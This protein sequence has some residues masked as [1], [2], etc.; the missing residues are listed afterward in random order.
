M[1]LLHIAII[2]SFLI[3]YGH[4]GYF[5]LK[6]RKIK[7]IL[8]LE[9]ISI[10]SVHTL[11]YSFII[12]LI[13]TFAIGGVPLNFHLSIINILLLVLLILALVFVI[14]SR[15]QLS[16]FYSPHIEILKNHQLI[17]T[18]F[19]RY[20][21]HPIYYSETLC[22]ICLSFLVNNV[23]A[24]L[25]MTIWTTSILI[26]IS[27]EDKLLYKTFPKYQSDWSKLA[28]FFFNKKLEP[29]T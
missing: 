18:G 24:Y 17:D 5:F 9:R 8:L 21:S 19:Y 3:V 29:K 1:P 25:G 20:I 23:Y 15:I 22:F 6:N 16:F 4:A 10:Q 2:V 13:Y 12:L 14:L 26:K 11:Y 28:V 27:K 7:K